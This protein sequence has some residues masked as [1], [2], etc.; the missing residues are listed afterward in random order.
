MQSPNQVELQAD[1]QFPML[2]CPNSSWSI[3]PKPQVRTLRMDL[4][5]HRTLLFVPL[6]NMATLKSS[7]FTFLYYSSF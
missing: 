4:E 6:T 7:F 3:K 1:K 5:G 2:S